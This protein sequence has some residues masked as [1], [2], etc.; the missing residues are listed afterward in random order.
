[1]VV[2]PVEVVSEAGDCDD[3]TLISSKGKRDC[4]ALVS[5]T[6]PLCRIL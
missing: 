1:M 2:I 3:R 4:S 5:G 6:V